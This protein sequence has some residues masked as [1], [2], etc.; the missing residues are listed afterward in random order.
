VAEALVQKNVHRLIGIGPAIGNHAGLFEAAGLEALFF[1]ATDVFMEQ[2]HPSWF[3]DEAILLKGARRFEFERIARMLEKKV[4]QTLLEINLASVTHNLKLYQHQLH[5][6]TK[7][8]VMVKAFSYG[9]GAYEIA[10]LLQFHHVDYLAVAYA[11]EGVE[12][13]KAGIRLPIM[14]MNAEESSFPLLTAFDLQPEL[15]SVEMARSLERFL[16]SE[17]LV[18]FPVHLKLDT[19]MHRLG[20]SPDEVP[21]LADWLRRTGTFRVQ[22]VFSHLVASEDPAEDEFSRKQGE[23]F[24]LACERLQE[25]VGYPILRHIANTAAIRRHPTLQLD[26]VRLGIGLYGVD[27]GMPEDSGLQEV[28]TLRTTIAQ[29]RALPAGETV[30]YNRKGKLLRD[31]LIATIRIGYADGYPRSL[32]N[33]AGNVWIRGKLFP[34][35]GSVCMDMTM[36]DITGHPEIIAGE[37]VVL[38]G[39]ELPVARLAEWA[40]TI[41][42]EILTGIS[43][44]VQ[45]VYYEE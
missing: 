26:M 7:L 15:Y 19:G 28:S 12:L 18:D 27:P 25:G 1:P 2:A 35:I 40:G 23:N 31:S 33:G 5:P 3:R 6:Q 39:R 9:A 41:P 30:G 11:D 14:V 36:V 37:E 42:Y 29:V 32:G 24:L 4:H 13:R 10:S 22:S 17:G 8:M 45:R 16:Q 34:V 43:Q 20:F 21:A 44:R 38:F